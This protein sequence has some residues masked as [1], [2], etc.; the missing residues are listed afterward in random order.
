MPRF[1]VIICTVAMVWAIGS[2]ALREEQSATSTS[3]TTT[4]AHRQPTTGLS[5]SESDFVVLLRNLYKDGKYNDLLRKTARIDYDKRD[6]AFCW[7]V[8]MLQSQAYRRAGSHLAAETTVR[9]LL[10]YAQKRPGPGRKRIIFR[11][12]NLY[13]RIE[14]YWDFNPAGG[15]ISPSSLGKDKVRL[16]PARGL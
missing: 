14:G 12:S 11:R 9:K 10:K 6:F 1:I 2:G 8:L 13:D 15:G 16:V 4:Q 3:T 5:I 7:E